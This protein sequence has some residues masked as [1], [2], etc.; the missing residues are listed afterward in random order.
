MQIKLRF[1]SRLANRWAERFS[2][3]RF[4]HAVQVLAPTL[5]ALS[6]TT[7]AHAQGTMDFSGAQTL[8]GTFKTFAMYAGAVICLGGLIFAGIRMMSGR[9]QDAIP[10]LFGALFGAGVL[11]WGAGWI[12]SLTGQQM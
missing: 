8:M 5:L 3:Q 1:D 6:I 12:G 7:V 11:G 4:N 9:F 10:G 2:K